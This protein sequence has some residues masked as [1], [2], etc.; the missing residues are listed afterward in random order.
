M[1][2]AWWEVIGYHTTYPYH[3]LSRDIICKFFYS[4]YPHTISSTLSSACD[5]QHSIAQHLFDLSH[6]IGKKKLVRHLYRLQQFASLHGCIFKSNW[7]LYWEQIQCSIMLSIDIKWP[8]ILVW[9][10]LSRR[11]S[12][13]STFSI[14]VTYYKYYIVLTTSVAQCAV[15]YILYHSSVIPVSPQLATLTSLLQSPRV[16]MCSFWSF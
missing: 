9:G 16:V 15:V 11:Q 2:V 4:T 5:V 3:F 6:Q 12:D 7:R 13:V 10:R 8:D 14:P 1:G